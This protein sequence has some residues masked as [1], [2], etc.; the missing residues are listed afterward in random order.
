MAILAT[1]I[2]DIDKASTG[3]IPMMKRIEGIG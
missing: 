1:T 2:S 3:E